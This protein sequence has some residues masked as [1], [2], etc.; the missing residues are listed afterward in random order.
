[1]IK[2]VSEI[3]LEFMNLLKIEYLFGIPG[4][5]MELLYEIEK[6]KKIKKILTKTEQGT[7]FR[8]EVLQKF[9]EESVHVLVVQDRGQ[10]I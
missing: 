5:N 1:M 6:D 4:S 8:Q 9:Q 10:P 3:I 2:K 7:T